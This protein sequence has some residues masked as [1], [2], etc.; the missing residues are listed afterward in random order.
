MIH[1]KASA[2]ESHDNCH[3]G[4]TSIKQDQM[5]KSTTIAAVRFWTE[6]LKRAILIRYGPVGNNVNAVRQLL[7]HTKQ[8]V[9]NKD[10]LDLVLYKFI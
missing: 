5:L 8:V 2:V 4:N 7:H 6:Q 9:R 10:G 1:T 3:T